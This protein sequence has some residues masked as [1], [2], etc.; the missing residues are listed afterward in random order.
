MDKILKPA[1]LSIDPNSSSA[2]KEWRHWVRIFRSYMRRFV[3]SES[4]VAA[5]QDKLD[6]L[7]SCTTPEVY[8]FFDH[9]TTY[10]EAEAVLDKL[11]VKQP[12][13]IFARYL[14][15]SAKQS[16]GQS[17]AD[18]NCSLVR[19]AKDCDFKDVSAT[20]NRD[21]LMRDAFISGILSSEIRQRLLEN[22]TLSMREAYEIAV[23]LE[24]AKHE[25]RVFCNTATEHSKLPIESQSTEA[26]FVNTEDET[27]S[28]A[29]FSKSVCNKCASSKPHDYR[30]CKAGSLICYACGE[31]GH[32]SRACS[33][34]R[35]VNS[36]TRNSKIRKGNSVAVVEMT[37]PAISLNNF[38]HSLHKLGANDE[39]DKFSNVVAI[40]EIN[41]KCYKT[42]LDSGSSKCFVKETVANAIGIQKARFCFDVG[43]AQATNRVKVKGFC[44][45]SLKFL[46][47][48]Y[49]NIVLYVMK[50]LCVDIILGR[51]FLGLHESVT[52]QFEGPDARLVVSKNESC[53]VTAANVKTPSLFGNLISGWKPISTKSRRYNSIDKAFIKTTVDN[54]KLAGTVRPSNSPWRAQC[55][56]VKRDGKPQRVA[57]DYSQTVNIFTERDSFPIPLI[58]ELINQLAPC[59]IYASYDLK[60]A[61]HQVP[62]S[63]QD[64]PFTAFEAC[65]EL[66]EFNVIPF[67]V[68]NGGPVFQ[69]VMTDIITDDHLYN[70]YVYFDNVVIGADS[71]KEL[72]VRASEFKRSMDSRGM[73]LNHSKTVY[74]VK[75][76]NILGYCIGDG[77]IKP[78]PERLKPLLD[79]PPPTSSKSLKRVLG[80]FAYYAKWIS[81]FSD[82]ISRLKSSK[83]FPLQSLEME[84]FEGLKQEIANAA[85]QAIN[86]EHQFTVECDASEVAVSATLNQHGRPVGF[87]SRSLSLAPSNDI[88]LLKKKQPR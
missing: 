57:I 28:A 61:Y 76:L 44:Q 65:G 31:K 4:S 74:G 33:L 75:E 84:D 88:R 51:D 41:G 27:V 16:P 53:A 19:L 49:E 11:Y 40:S 36:S 63:D 20:Q 46:G 1:R 72:D 30:K 68:T 9:C 78:D 6:A 37:S 86:E 8:E 15:S 81:K 55:V 66:L 60:K 26:C 14:L 48:T 77:T 79:L 18:F 39:A 17:L 70:T 43:M 73:V 10:S 69:R 34:Q 32:L 23:T 50:D 38:V 80:M 52:F 3:T 22:K 7:V 47:R 54:W 71:A 42:L 21:D 24:D 85:L 13:N 45:V 67:G 58:D 87:M 29:N 2:T 25:N 56:V 82:R 62:I 12:N 83:Q 5:E 35:K 59:K 64:K